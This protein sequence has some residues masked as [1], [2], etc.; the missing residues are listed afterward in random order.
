MSALSHADA[1]RVIDGVAE[2]YLR[3]GYGDPL[4]NRTS[5]AAEWLSY[6]DMMTQAQF[7]KG[8]F[9]L[10]PYADFA[11]LGVHEQVRMLISYDCHD[12]DVGVDADV[13]VDI[14]VA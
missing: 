5:D 9:A 3:V 7:T 11:V 8:Q 13:D 1:T 2:N 10:M 4:L 12:V 6:N 14:D